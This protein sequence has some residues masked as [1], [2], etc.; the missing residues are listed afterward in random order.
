MP[1]LLPFDL[2]VCVG[3]ATAGTQPLSSHHG[4]PRRYLCSSP[5]VASVTRRRARQTAP[6]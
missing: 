1:G 6:G 3:L 5:P 4:D 2:E